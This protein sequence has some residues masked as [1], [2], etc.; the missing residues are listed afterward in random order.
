MFEK[1]IANVYF[2]ISQSQNS[3]KEKLDLKELFRFY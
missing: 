1:F 3:G 2:L